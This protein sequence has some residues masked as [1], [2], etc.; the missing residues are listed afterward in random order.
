M[1]EKIRPPHLARKA[2]LYVRQSS[3]GQVLNN[4]ES[5]RL[6]YAMR[7][8]LIALGWTD[9][10]V[11]DEDLGQSAAGTVSRAGF[12]RLVAAV[13]LGEVG[14]VA[15]RE[16]SRFARNNREW[17]QLIEVCRVVDTLLI[18]HEAVYDPRAGNDRLLLGMKGSLNE[19][20]LELL[21][22]RAVEARRAKARRGEFLATVPVG[23]V[24]TDRGEYEI[25]PDRRVQE[26]IRLAF[27]K[28]LKLGSIRQVLQWFLHQGLEFPARK[29]TPGGWTSVWQRPKYPTFQRLMTNPAYG[30]AYAFGRTEMTVRY[31]DGK[32]VKKSVAKSQSEQWLCLIPDHHDGYVT[33]EVFQRI[34]R[35]RS[36]NSQAFHPSKPGAAKRGPALLCGLLRCRR[37]GR[38]LVVGYGG[39]EG[40]VI[41]Y[42]CDRGHLDCGQPKCIQIGGTSVDEAVSREAVRVLQ[43]GAIEAAR[44]LACEGGRRQDDVIAAVQ[45]ESEAARYAADRAQRQYDAADPENRLVTGELER[46]WNAALERVREIEARLARLEGANAHRA[47]IRPDD[48]GDLASD[49]QRVWDHPGTDVRLKKRLLRTLIQEIVVDTDGPAG[50]TLV[51]I[52]WQGGV[53][54]ELRVRRRK[55]GSNRLHTPPET[56]EVVRQLNRICDDI[57]I[58]GL[59]NRAGIRTGHGNRWNADRV[60][61]MRGSFDIPTYT[62]DRQAGEGWLNLTDAARELGVATATLRLGIEKGLLKAEHPLPEGPWIIHR[63]QLTTT[64]ADQLVRRARR[65]RPGGAKANPRQQILDF[66]EQTSEEAV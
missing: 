42:N 60:K 22:H 16:V 1:S 6:Q 5:Q 17:Q 33:W 58:A 9:I 55:R 41:R 8:R 24:K 11:I 52:H 48:L 35:M 61:S 34:Q 15:A 13:C 10:E 20:E 7:E 50:E 53:H 51:L 44:A 49:F 19:Y 36:D 21:R 66:P 28:M 32:P 54:T 64:Q 46:R 38:K 62:P 39:R 56:V 40:N 37:C 63:D 12:E 26:A 18:D 4:T 65:R 23:F 47:P 57:L 25:D 29:L 31:V 30:G 59:L 3:P 27:A 2:I 43:P 14:A 45:R